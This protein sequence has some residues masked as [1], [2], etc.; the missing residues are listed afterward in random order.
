M[1]KV[2]LYVR[3]SKDENKDDE[4][5]QNPENQ[6]TPLRKYAEAM[7]W[8]I[9][10]EYI[11]QKTGTTANRPEFRRMFNDA[12]TGKF[13]GV[14][15][16]AIDRFSREGI[17]ETLAYVKQLRENQV[18]LKSYQESWFDTKSETAELLLA[19]MAWAAKKERDRISARTIAGI[20]Q[21][22]A[23]GTY[24]GG[25]PKRCLACGWQH[26]P[27]KPCKHP[28]DGYPQQSAEPPKE[29]IKPPSLPIQAV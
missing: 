4:R 14:L 12:K 21:K 9:I 7:G 11:D 17:L 20:T 28:K 27:K 22:K 26:S 10:K 5:F 23:D 25:K 1:E 24:K 8:E 6:I 19:V 15:V 18:W 16:W 13:N 29:P 2:A 3:V